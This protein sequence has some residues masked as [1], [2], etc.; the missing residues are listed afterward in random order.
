MKKAR[1]FLSAIVVLA[2]VGGA[3]AFKPAAFNAG[4]IFC[5]ITNP[6]DRN[7]CPV[8]ASKDFA[9]GATFLQD[10]DCLPGAPV[11]YY[12]ATYTVTSGGNTYTYCTTTGTVQG[13]AWSKVAE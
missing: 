1:I 9:T 2:L 4:N 10:Y 6:S 3:L 5:P 8:G 11:G 7:Y 13:D 12:T